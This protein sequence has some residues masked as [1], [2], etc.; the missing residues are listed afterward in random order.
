MRSDD[1]KALQRALGLS[2]DGIYGPITDERVS[3]W[4]RAQEPPIVETGAGPLTRAALHV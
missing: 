4:K 3:E 2:E 1:V